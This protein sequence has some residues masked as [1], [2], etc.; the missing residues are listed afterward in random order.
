MLFRSY[1]Q[2]SSVEPDMSL[3]SVDTHTIYPPQLEF[4][5]NDYSY[6]TGSSQ[7]TVVSSSPLVIT[8]PNNVG[9][10]LQQAV[11]RFRVN[12]RPQYPPRVFATGSFYTFNYFL[13]QKV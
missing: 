1:N 8:L 10:Y 2:S 12:C 13:S 5:W 3:F 4:R 9:M 11:Q 6:N 7:Q